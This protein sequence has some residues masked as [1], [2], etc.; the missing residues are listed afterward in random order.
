M[1][2]PNNLLDITLANLTTSILSI[3]IF[4]KP[5]PNAIDTN[6]IKDII[7]FDQLPRRYSSVARCNSIAID[8][9]RN[10]LRNTTAIYTANIAA[11]ADFEEVRYPDSVLKHGAVMIVDYRGTAAPVQTSASPSRPE[12]YIKFFQ[13]LARSPR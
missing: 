11:V 10:P 1:P 13:V 12:H 8:S 7:L 2:I 5:I 4:A 3:I 6:T 9:I